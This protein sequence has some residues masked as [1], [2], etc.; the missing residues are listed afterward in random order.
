MVEERQRARLRSV[1]SPNSTGQPPRAWLLPIRA[2]RRARSCS[3]YSQ[4]L[5]DE[6]D[7]TG[8]LRPLEKRASMVRNIRNMFHRMGATEQDVR[9]WRGIVASLLGVSVEPRTIRCHSSAPF[10]LLRWPPTMLASA[11]GR[12]G[13]WM[14]TGVDSVER[15]RGRRG[16]NAAD[17]R[18]G[19]CRR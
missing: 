8:F 1:A 3:V 17:R 13:L 18:A 6:L 19:K 11:T 15:G 7:R 2:R 14:Q 12:E 16:L 10:L 9:T 5:E 4:H